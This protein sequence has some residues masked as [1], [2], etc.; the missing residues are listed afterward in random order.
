MDIENR[1]GSEWKKTLKLKHVIANKQHVLAIL[2]SMV[3]MYN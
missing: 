1:Q 3:F 2:E